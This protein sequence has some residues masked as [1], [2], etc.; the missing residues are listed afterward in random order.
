MVIILYVCYY[1]HYTAYNTYFVRLLPF[2]GHWICKIQPNTG[3][4]SLFTIVWCWDT[5]SFLVFSGYTAVRFL[6]KSSTAVTDWTLSLF[7]RQES[8]MVLLLCRQIQSGMPEYCSCFQPLLRRTLDPSPSTVHLCRQWKHMTILKM[9][10][11]CI[12]VL[13]ILHVLYVLNASIFIIRIIRVICI[14]RFCRMV[15]VDWIPDYLRA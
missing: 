10:G 6:Q 12:Y 8:T 15:E 2:L 3:V 14:I 9:V 1:T 7:G 5:P 4:I 11:L 13:H